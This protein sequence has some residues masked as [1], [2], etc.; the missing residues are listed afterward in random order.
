MEVG[1]SIVQLMQVPPDITLEFLATFARF[2][3]ALKRAGYANGNEQGV[4]PDWN[5]LGR[6]LAGGPDAALAEVYRAGEYLEANPPMKQVQRGGVLAWKRINEEPSRIQKLLFDVR[7]VR[8]NLFHGG[9]FPEGLVHEPSRNVQLIQSCLS[10]LNALA[11]VPAL[12]HI[13]QYFT[14]E[15]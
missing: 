3:Y 5:R 1:R 8:N 6:E 14:A 13:S 11:A 7:T 9:K 10:I 15:G 12:S 2:E 4:Q